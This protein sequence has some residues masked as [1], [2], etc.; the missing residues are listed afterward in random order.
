M[1]EETVT[2]LMF[3]SSNRKAGRT[4]QAQRTLLR[5]LGYDPVQCAVGRGLLRTTT[6]PTL[7]LLLLLLS[8]SSSSSSSYPPPPPTLLIR[9]PLLFLLLLRG[10]IEPNHSTDV[11]STS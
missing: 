8:S 7:N 1:G 10:G 9:P 4:R 5:L 3:A 2:W 11:E 6:Q